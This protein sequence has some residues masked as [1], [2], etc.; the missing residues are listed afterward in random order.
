MEQLIFLADECVC[1]CTQ[2]CDGTEA[3]AVKVA[4]REA[5]I[6]RRVSKRAARRRSNWKKKEPKITK[7]SYSSIKV[8]QDNIS[9]FKMLL[10]ARPLF[11]NF[12]DDNIFW[13]QLKATTRTWSID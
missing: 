1:V 11:C 10:Y 13:R 12:N 9:C 2:V 6:T 7:D 4:K 5:V 8:K 3:A